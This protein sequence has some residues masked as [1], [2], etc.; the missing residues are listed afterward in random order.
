MKII[1]VN[2]SISKENTRRLVPI[3]KNLFYNSAPLGLCYLASFLIMEGHQVEIVDGAVEGLSIEEIIGRIDKFSPDIAGITTFTV[4]VSSAYGLVREIKKRFPLIKIIA[5]G[6]HI[7]SNPCDLINHPEVDIAVIG[8]GEITFRDLAVAINKGNNIEEVNGIAFIRAGKLFFTPCREYIAN[9]DI[10]PF[11]ARNLL[12]LRLYRPQPND[13][14]ELPKLSMI[15]S[16]GCPYSCIFCDKNVFKNKY[17]SFSAEY[18]VREMA[19]LV[20]D[21]KAKDIAFVDSTFTPSRQR[22]YDIVNEIKKADLD[23]TWTCAVRA[24]IL[25]RDVLTAMKE[26]GCWRVRFGIESGNE[27][28]LKFINKRIT[29]EQIRKVANWAYELNLQPKAFFIVGHLTDTKQTI[30]ETISFA[31]S[32]PLRDITVQFNTPLVNTFQYQLLDKYGKI[33]T[34]DLGKYSFW[35]PVFIPHGLSYKELCCYYRKFYLK[36]YLRPVIWYR[37][38]KGITSFSDI[39]KYVRGLSILFYFFISWIRKKF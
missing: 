1:L 2:P 7:T 36:F 17:R 21:F 5:G 18:I 31:C 22:V 34:E 24:D 15:S 39:A 33:L 14:R 16:R 10:L 11:P 26:A 19:H 12:P 32:L 30:E 8:E 25:D 6:P 9:L 38:L 4:S 37:H 20:K 27:E 29:K 28:V 13:Q 3:V 35:E 23:V